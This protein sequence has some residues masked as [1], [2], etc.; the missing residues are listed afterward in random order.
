ML[1]GALQSAYLSTMPHVNR[2]NLLSTQQI[3]HLVTAKNKSESSG[4]TAVPVTCPDP[5]C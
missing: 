3:C 5:A 4:V 2:Q 1:D